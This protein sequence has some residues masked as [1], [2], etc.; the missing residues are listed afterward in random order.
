MRMQWIMAG[1]LAL[2]GAWP[3]VAACTPPVP[4]AADA[5]PEKPKLPDKPA[6]L[7]AKGGC[8]GWEAYSYNDAIKA[9]NAQAQLF[10]PLAEAYVQKLNAYVKASGEYANC[11]VKSLQ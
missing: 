9:Y 6:C 10:R 11:E 4:P 1:A 8:P 7:D 5:R 2:A 3:A